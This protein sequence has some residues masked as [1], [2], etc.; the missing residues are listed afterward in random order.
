MKKTFSFLRGLLLLAAVGLCAAQA[1]AQNE[2]SYRELVAKLSGNGFLDNWL[3]KKALQHSIA[4]T[5]GKMLDE[6]PQTNTLPK[7]EKEKRAENI[8]KLYL[9]EQMETDRTELFASILPQGRSEEELAS[10]VELTNLP[11]REGYGAAE[12][13]ILNL[14]SSRSIQVKIDSILWP[15]HNHIAKGKIKKPEEIVPTEC[16]ESYQEAF[17]DFWHKTE[18]ARWLYNDVVFLLQM[19]AGGI[20]LTD[21]DGKPRNVPS[22]RFG[23]RKEQKEHMQAINTYGKKNIPVLWRNLFLAHSVTEEDLR[24]LTPSEN[25]Q[26]IN[27]LKTLTIDM[28]LQKDILVQEM[29]KNFMNW[30]ATWA[31]DAD[32]ALLTKEVPA[33]STANEDNALVK[34]ERHPMFPGGDKALLAWL[35][36]QINYPAECQKQGIQGRVY[37]SFVVGKDGNISQ[38]VI[39]KSPNWA[40]S[41]EVLRILALMPRW[42]PG[43]QDGKP[44]KVKYSVPIMFRL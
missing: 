28:K 42:Q 16:P 29:Q 39:L 13:K 32:L 7:K 35:A 36:L 40:M 1:G 17:N 14:Q 21:A 23:S 37:A 12:E 27:S 26:T 20:S 11:K 5:Y 3:S 44:V 6:D 34:P 25:L 9:K 43:Y 10:Y 4:Q 18:Q 2:N 22:N 19:T 24:V 31:K 33:D 30:Y 8:A 15:I 38:T 41:R